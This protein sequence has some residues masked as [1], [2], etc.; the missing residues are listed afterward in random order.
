[1]RT[2][3]LDYLKLCTQCSVRLRVEDKVPMLMVGGGGL[4]PAAARLLCVFLS[5]L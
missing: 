5:V 4:E 2:L 1:M 3:T